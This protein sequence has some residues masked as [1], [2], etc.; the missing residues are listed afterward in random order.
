MIFSLAT[1]GYNIVATAFPA[2]LNRTGMPGEDAR[3]QVAVSIIL[4]E[5]CRTSGASQ[6][7]PACHAM[8][9][10]IRQLRAA[11]LSLQQVRA[12]IFGTDER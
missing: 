4:D 3:E 8:I 9:R 1:S 7:D 2:L 11:G 10:R 12:D 5:W 6:S